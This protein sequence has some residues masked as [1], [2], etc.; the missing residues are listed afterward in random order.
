MR[1]YFK[2]S[3]KK[4]FEDNPEAKVFP[5]FQNLTDEQM[6]YIALMYS[7]RSPIKNMEFEK[8]QKEAIRL[9]KFVPTPTG[10]PSKWESDVVEVRADY[11][12]IAM[13]KF[14][15]LQFDEDKED[16]D[17]YCEQLE[18]FR[19]FLRIKNKK[20]TDIDKALKIMKE[21]P[22]LTSLKS[23]LAE[24]LKLRDEIDL[25]NQALDEVDEDTEF[26]AIELFDINTLEDE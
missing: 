1:Y 24:K 4:F 3:D 11:I 14:K 7:Y 15:E 9:A 22:Y 18:D 23:E 5:E 13:A 12:K 2:I 25:S 8:K 20:G 21:M 16:F 19:L 10:R 6:K 26:S 17:A